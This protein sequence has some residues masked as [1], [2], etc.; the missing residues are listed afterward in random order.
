[1]VTNRLDERMEALEEDGDHVSMSDKVAADKIKK[2]REKKV[3]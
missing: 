3:E 1:M 2:C